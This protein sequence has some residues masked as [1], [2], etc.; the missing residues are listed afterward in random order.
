MKIRIDV[1]DTLPEDEIIIKCAAVDDKIT[2][3]YNYALARA[4]EAPSIVFYKD[5]S[6]YY[7]ALTDILFFETEGETVYAHTQSD[8]FKIK[9]RLYELEKLLPPT[10]VRI[11]KSSIVNSEKIYS[12]TR[13]I[14]TSSL[15]EFPGTHKHVYVSRKYYPALKEK[16]QKRR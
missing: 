15:I 4:K 11:S 16:M 6:E 14:A 3:I 13:N 1:V 2:D 5:N 9:H 8:S 10:F 7:L 12:I